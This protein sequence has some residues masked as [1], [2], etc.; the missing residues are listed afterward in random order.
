ML[1]HRRTQQAPD[2]VREIGTA[3][4]VL[5]AHYG[6]SRAK[7]LHMLCTSAQDNHRSMAETVTKII[8]TETLCPCSNRQL[9]LW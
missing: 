2:S 9:S 4:G 1:F 5:M 6:T 8:D 3:A 7:A